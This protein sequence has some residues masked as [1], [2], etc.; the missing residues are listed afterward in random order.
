MAAKRIKKYAYYSKNTTNQEL[1]VSQLL[2]QAGIPFKSQVVFDTVSSRF[3]VDFFINNEIILEVTSTQM[4]NVA[5]PIKKRALKLQAKAF[6]I[7]IF[8][9]LPIWVVMSSKNPLSEDH[10]FRTRLMT[11]TIDELF[12]SEE[13]MMNRLLEVVS[14]SNSNC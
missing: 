8:Y 13:D 5:T 6:L 2:K 7:K 11:P 14:V 3:V 10:K 12:F 4:K 9:E 1:M